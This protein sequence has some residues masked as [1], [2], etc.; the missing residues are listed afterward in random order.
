MEIFDTMG[1][2]KSLALSIDHEKDMQVSDPAEKQILAYIRA[3][4]YNNAIK[5]VQNKKT[6]EEQIVSRTEVFD[7]YPSDGA[8]AF[9]EV[10][11]KMYGWVEQKPIP[12]TWFSPEKPPRM[13]VVELPY[14]RTEV[15]WGEIAVPN[16]DGSMHLMAVNEHG[17]WKF[18]I[19]ADVKKKHIASVKVLCEMTREHVRE[20]SIYRGQ[21]VRL[22]WVEEEPTLFTQGEEGF[23]TP[24]FMAKTGLTKSDIVLP[25]QT[26]D[27]VDASIFSLIANAKLAKEMGIPTKRLCLAAGPY[28]TGKTLCAT[29]TAEICREHRRTFI[30]LRDVTHLADA[31]YFAQQYAPACVFAE[32]IDIVKDTE[33]IDAISNTIDGVDTKGLDVL[34]ILTTNHVDRIPQKFLRS[35]RSDMIIKFAPPD[36]KAAAQLILKYGGATFDLDFTE[37]DALKV[38][39]VLSGAEMIPA[40]IREVVERSKLFALAKGR[41]R[42]TRI[43]LERAANGVLEQ[44]E[45]LKEK[46]PNIIPDHMEQTGIVVRVKEN[47]NL[48]VANQ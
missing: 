22:E 35:G 45:M 25:E 44:C 38:G 16:I 33:T 30:Y 10:L 41:R 37:E 48:V 3:G 43:D 12:A 34:F 6:E 26:W 36:T 9:T 11:K 27:E 40:S 19:R 5:W 47:H 31:I 28:G 2:K 18:A 39:A 8:Y 20:K 4:K 32:D 17:V 7:A 42:I 13:L 23:D 15:P 29:I 1:S 24:R 14:G 21:A 46:R